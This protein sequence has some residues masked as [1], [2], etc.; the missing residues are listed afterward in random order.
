MI[1][2]QVKQLIHESDALVNQEQAE[3][4]QEVSW[5]DAQKNLSDDEKLTALKWVAKYY[6]S[7]EFKQLVKEFSDK[8]KII[9]EEIRE[10]VYNR[11]KTEANHSFLDRC[12]VYME[13]IK[14]VQEKTANEIF[15]NYLQA[16]M[17]AQDSIIL[18]KKWSIVV[19]EWIELLVDS[20]IFT[21]TDLLKAKKEIYISLDAFMKYLVSLYDMKGKLDKQEKS[22]DNPYQPYE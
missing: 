12:V 6:Y 18:N 9:D 22:Q 1:E 5:I 3:E 16:R 4:E 17:D 20:P 7:D 13:A 10:V 2:D 21:D 19:A 14:E 11:T 8:C 15:K